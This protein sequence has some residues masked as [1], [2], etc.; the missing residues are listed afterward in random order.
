V[1]IFQHSFKV[2]DILELQHLDFSFVK[3]L[4]GGEEFLAFLVM[5]EVGG[6]PSA[7]KAT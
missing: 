2:L 5:D 3:V 1:Q 4:N 7:L 6:N